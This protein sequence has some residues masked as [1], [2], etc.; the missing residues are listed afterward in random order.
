MKRIGIRYWI[1]LLGLLAVACG[2]RAGEL[3]GPPVHASEGVVEALDGRA[4]GEL[5]VDREQMTVGEQLVVQVR[6]RGELA[7]GFGRP[8]MVERWDGEG[9]VETE[10]SRRS[11]WTMDYL[12]AFPG[13]EGIEQVWPFGGTE[14][15]EPGW[16]RFTKRVNAEDLDGESTQL[17]LR[18]RV[19]VVAKDQS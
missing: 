11:A 16:Y 10:A 15:S 8:V 17:E 19:R 13:E 9:W 7:L 4:A 1:G 5:W 6:N 14:V 3:D 12:Y 18:A 2:E